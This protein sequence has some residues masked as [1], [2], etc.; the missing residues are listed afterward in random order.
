MRGSFPGGFRVGV[1]TGLL[2]GGVVPI[3]HLYRLKDGELRYRGTGEFAS[4]IMRRIP[5]NAEQIQRFKAALDLLD[6]WR[7]RDDYKP[8]DVNLVVEN[9]GS[10]WF[11]AKLEDQE[12]SCGGCNAFPSYGDAAQTALDGERFTL[13]LAA[14]YDMFSI[15]GYIHQAQHRQDHQDAEHEV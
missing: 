5:A 13:L 6:V 14:L 7:W 15:A 11:T 1:L 8:R 3:D 10:W 2:N 12:C 4:L 9:G